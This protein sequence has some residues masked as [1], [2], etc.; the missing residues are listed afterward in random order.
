MPRVLMVCASVAALLSTSCGGGDGEDGTFPLSKPVVCVSTA[1]DPDDIG[2]RG[3][4][5][6]LVDDGIEV[7]WTTA[8]PVRSTP[9]GSFD[10]ELVDEYGI[11]RGGLSLN[12]WNEELAAIFGQDYSADVES[13]RLLDSEP[14][15]GKPTI[16]GRTVTMVYPHS[17]IEA[18][19]RTHWRAFVGAHVG[20]QDR[21]D[22]C[23]DPSPG[24]EKPEPL[25][26]PTAN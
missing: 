23:P 10:V 16:A 15:D 7:T 5:L 24:D 25:R 21:D 12:L 20:G 13:L 17:A 26:L 6:Q 3:T 1:N 19:D 9:G 18:E 22:W 4:R 8:G 14:V 2:L 11:R